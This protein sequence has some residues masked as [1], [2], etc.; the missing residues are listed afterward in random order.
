MAIPAHVAVNVRM[1][2]PD[3]LEGIGRFTFESLRRIVV[4]HP[5]VR[6]SFL[7]DRPFHEDFIFAPNVV[8]VVLYPPARHPVL[9]YIWF[10]W[11]VWW[12]LR[13]NKPDV[14]L[15]TDGYLSLTSGVKSLPVIHDLNFIHRRGDLPR[16]V[17][18]YYNY[19]FPRF[20]RK[21]ARIVTVSEFS[22]SDICQMFGITPL[23]VDVVYNG[24]SDEFHPCGEDI[25]AKIREQYTDGKP[26][27]LYIGAIHPRKNLTGLLLAF[28]Q[29][30]S[31]PGAPDVQLLVVGERMF[32]NHP[33]D[34]VLRKM[35]YRSSVRFVGRLPQADLPFLTGSAL[36][37]TFVPFFEGFGI[38][39]LEAMQSG[40]PVICSNS[41]SLPEVAGDA[42][43]LTD[44]Y[45]TGQIANA[46]FRLATDD[47]L[48]KELSVKGLERSKVFSWDNTADLLWQSIEKCYLLVK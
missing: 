16:L 24:A 43:L 37:L 22:K 36:A 12:W 13:R 10:E 48:R 7:F 31:T 23:Q 9:W 46:M 21:A 29:F 8:P 33:V 35:Q 45:D 5:E 27:F 1:L 32:K 30:R 18:A 34:H 6:F 19:F 28:D 25:Q 38:P 2:L 41:T 14:F 40:V 17:S 42:A 39:V 44:P 3:K 47:A 11:S 15:S 4:Q 20:A 26:F